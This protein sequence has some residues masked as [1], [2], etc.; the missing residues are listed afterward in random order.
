MDNAGIGVDFVTGSKPG[1]A[2]P[3]ALHTL[4]PRRSQVLR[5]HIRDLF[6]IGLILV[7]MLH[8][9]W[10]PLTETEV[11]SSGREHLLAPTEWARVITCVGRYPMSPLVD[12]ERYIG[13]YAVPFVSPDLQ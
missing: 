11:S 10:L 4:M 8:K 12:M 9:S 7:Q 6:R 2:A 1:Y 3:G 13:K 5:R